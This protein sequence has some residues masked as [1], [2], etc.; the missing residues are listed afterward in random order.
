MKMARQAYL[1]VSPGLRWTATLR[2][3]V[4]GGTLSVDT[5]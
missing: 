5:T 2:A 1:G 3:V 4:D